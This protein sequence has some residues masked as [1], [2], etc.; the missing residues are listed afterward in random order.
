MR[1]DQL[2]FMARTTNGVREQTE[3]M[4]LLWGEMHLTFFFK[5]SMTTSSH[6]GFFKDGTCPQTVNLERCFEL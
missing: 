5:N 1:L 2:Q 4:S 6:S 3:Q